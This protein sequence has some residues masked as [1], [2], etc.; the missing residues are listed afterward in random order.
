MRRRERNRTSHS[1]PSGTKRALEPLVPETE[2][3]EAMIPLTS[4]LYVSG[5]IACNQRV[6]V[7]V[8]TGYFIEKSIPAAAEYFQRKA[9]FLK[10]KIEELQKPVMAKMKEKNQL[11][12]LIQQQTAAMQA[13]AGKK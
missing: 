10:A 2:G 1:T 5:K 7:D 9:V 11:E 3:K 12:E 13:A 4:S 6:I 8:G